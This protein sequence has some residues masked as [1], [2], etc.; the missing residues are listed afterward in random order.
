MGVASLLLLLLAMEAPMAMKETWDL[1]T[2]DTA[3]TIAVDAH[4]PFVTRLQDSRSH[5]DWIA[6]ATP[7]PLMGRA[8]IGEREAKMDWRF[9]RAVRE[10][11]QG[12]LVLVFANAQPKLALRSIWRARPGRGPVEHWVE[13]GNQSGERVTVSHQDS[14]SLSGLRPKGQATIW[15]TKRGGSNASTQGGTFSQPLDARTNLALTSHCEDGA[16]PVPWLAV[17]MGEERG[18]YVGWE[19]SGLGRV[20]ARTG[21][22]PDELD[23]D[24]GLNPDFK[25][26]I[27][28]G[29]TFLVP[30]AFVGCYAGDLDEG[31]YSLHRFILEK[32]RPPMPD[33]C[34]DPILAYNLYLD[35]GGNNAREADV[36]R[37][38]ATCRDLGFEAFM[39]DAMWFPE[40]GDWRFDP[41]RFPNGVAPIEEFVRAH[42]M[43]L[44]LWCAWTNGGLSADPDA[45]SI[46]AHPDWFHQDYGPDWRPGPFTGGRLCLASPEAR[47]WAIRTTQR[48]VGSFRLRYL[49]HD[50]DPIVTR[51]NRATHR[52]R[53]GVDV[54]YWAA[55]GYY[56][57][58]EKLRK[59]FPNLILEN[60]S[61][62]GHIKDFGVIQRTHYTVTT[63]TL[64][65]LPDRQSLWDGTFAFPPLVL[66]AYTYDN[67]Y[68][69]KGDTPG[70]FLWRSGMMSAWQ[71]DPTDTPKWTAD[72]RESTR[73]SAQIY[74]EW[75][76]PILKD[77]KVHH[78]LPRPDGVHWDGMFYWSASLKRGTL[79]I[80]R[81]ESPD[82]EQTVK[83]KGL[84][85]Q[86]RYWLWCEDGSILPGVRSGSDLMGQ[87]LAIRLPQPYT[88]DLIFLQ[89]ESLGKPKGLEE[90]GEFALGKAEVISDPFSVS[91]RLTWQ[92]SAGARSYRAVVSESSDFRT[93]LA[94]A[95]AGAPSASLAKL[96][97]ARQLHWK[98]EAVAWGGR[99]WNS[100]DPGVFSTPKLDQLTGIT[101]ASDLQWAKA[102]VGANNPVRR[103][104]NYYG[105]PLAI[106][107]KPYPKGLWTHSFNDATP[108]DIVFDLAGKGFAAFKADVGLDDQSG[109]GSVQ[110]Q[111][112]LDGQLK[113]ASRV[114]RPRQ[115]HPLSVDV[116]GAKEITL[117]VLNGGDGYS[118]DHAVWGL[119]RFVGAGAKDH[120]DEGK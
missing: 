58:Q 48:L 83:L 43:F 52:H 61:G 25:T 80:F 7:V 116:R 66:Q 92:P 38:A 105:K 31:A 56:E 78:I 120:V 13:I 101:F 12:R 106:A 55:M 97:P 35:V 45:L 16:S 59:A 86:K 51:C 108:A 117:R 33:D 53:Y 82:A 94:E 89:D 2:E 77:C 84:D 60:C 74:K 5:H 57:V 75:I 69:V 62:G 93:V 90:P 6:G 64:S 32:L 98:V 3:I 18:L 23:L 10:P 70:T 54:S 73:R 49:K 46:R 111:V 44:A 96:P 40:T 68:P 28:P 103:D 29:E 30:P 109:G 99:R 50:I 85:P 19:F 63:D 21:R 87:G 9:E 107:G 119:A 42:G 37:S 76:R 114:L 112:F 91:A 24:I 39:P 27:E 113:A 1:S 4:Q 26:D 15:W 47:A 20:H 41:R 36:L 17:Q 104:S 102:T 118:C 34:P 8:W 22:S 79:Y 115:V 81:P 110:F 14:L 11:E 65:N 67:Y 71:I 100:G 88:S 72:E 95:V